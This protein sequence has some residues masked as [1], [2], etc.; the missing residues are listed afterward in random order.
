MGKL[1]DTQEGSIAG[2]IRHLEN[3]GRYAERSIRHYREQC[4]C[5]FALLPE[6][7]LPQAIKKEDVIELLK[8]MEKKGYSI[9]TQKGYIHALRRITK[10]YNNYT[11]DKMKIFWAHDQRPN[12]DWLTIEQART[13]M[14]CSKT[15]NQTL[16]VHCELCL[17]MR[18]CE[19]SRMRPEDVQEGYITIRGKGT[20]GNKPR[21]VPFHPRTRSII[22]MY[23]IY[24]Q[25]CLN[26][27]QE[28][29]HVT[30]AMPERMLIYVHGSRIYNYSEIK[31]SGLDKQLKILSK[32]VGFK[33]SNHTLRRTFGRMM[34]RSDVPVATIAK[35]LG[36]ESTNTTL[37]YIGV[38]FDDMDTAMRMYELR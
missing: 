35:M 32:N 9:Q 24:R 31:M 29:R 17:G 21:L 6:G 8:K 28:K 34:Y 18:R 20:H 23:M 33:F 1:P 22:Q 16:I 5:V 37:R 38:D 27:V 13:L 30:I 4:R 36:H 7:I 2:F 14:D 10:H 12:V 15:P 25:E 11:L 26:T 19:V 3:E